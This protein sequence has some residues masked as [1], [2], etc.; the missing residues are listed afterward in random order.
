MKKQEIE[1]VINTLEDLKNY[2]DKQNYN[3]SSYVN[4]KLVKVFPVLRK[5]LERLNTD[6]ISLNCP[7]L[8]EEFMDILSKDIDEESMKNV[9]NHINSILESL[10][11]QDY[12]IID[13]GTR[14]VYSNHLNKWS[15]II[16][17]K[18]TT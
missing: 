11:K 8:Y 6:E 12:K 16:S 5:E 18:Y 7:Q 14:W 3:L 17:I 15:V 1:E 2:T 13:Y 10:V 9:V 4:Q